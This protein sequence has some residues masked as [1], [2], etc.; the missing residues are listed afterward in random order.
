[1]R[2]VDRLPRTQ[3]DSCKRMIGCHLYCET[4]IENAYKLSLEELK[5][6]IDEEYYDGG[7]G[8]YHEVEMI[9]RMIEE[10]M[11]KL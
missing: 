8:D 11:S 2:I 1:M 5:L 3:C 10:L 4:D 9:V 6:M 7:Y